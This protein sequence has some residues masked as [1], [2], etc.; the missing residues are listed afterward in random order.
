MASS[1]QTPARRSSADSRRAAPTPSRRA[2][3]RPT[4]A[5]LQRRLGN[6]GV[7]ALLEQRRI[8][9][10]GTSSVTSSRPAIPP[11]SMPVPAAD[12]APSA[13]S[14]ELAVPTEST[15]LGQESVEVGGG[16]ASIPAT[17]QPALDVPAVDSG[18]G[19]TA[20]LTVESTTARESAPTAARARRHRRC[21]DHRST[22]R[23]PNSWPCSQTRRRRRRRRASPLL[24]TPRPLS[25]TCNGSK[26]RPRCL[27]FQRRQGYRQGD[28]TPA[29]RGKR[30]TGER[31]DR[32]ARML[33]RQRQVSRRRN[34]TSRSPRR[35][36]LHPCHRQCSSAVTRC[37]H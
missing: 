16:E 37:P 30:S 18:A 32:L 27:R 26:D 6:R 5:D 36:P 29:A 9:D 28:L 23:L 22:G 12:D 25:W 11:P 13:V 31:L 33:G 34:R 4:A 17:G 7:S 24:R 15:A 8:V 21:Q 20:A 14:E 19:P 10:E 2:T 3:T 35:R 1:R